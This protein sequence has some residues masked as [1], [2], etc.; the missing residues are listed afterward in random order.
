[1][2]TNLKNLKNLIA[3]NLGMKDTRGVTKAYNAELPKQ[4]NILQPLVG[5]NEQLIMKA[6]L[7]KIIDDLEATNKSEVL[8]FFEDD[9]IEENE[10][11]EE[12]TTE[13][14][15]AT[16]KSW[17][18]FMKGDEEEDGKYPTVH[19]LYVDYGGRYIISLTEPEKEPIPFPDFY[20]NDKYPLKLILKGLE[21]DFFFERKFTGSKT[22][23]AKAREGQDMYVLEETY[24]MW[25]STTMMESIAKAFDGK[26]TKQE[27]RL[28]KMKV[29]K[30][31]KSY[32]AYPVV[33]L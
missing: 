5:N 25:A 14:P 31:G 11:I 28:E 10:E 1:M 3:D 27:F 33:L 4:T 19:P 21:P 6:T 30:N 16:K 22:E 29:T 18:D 20:G 15:P 23:K 32:V 12:I 17:G 8:A 13:K 26:V 24:T 9:V 7:V 2:K